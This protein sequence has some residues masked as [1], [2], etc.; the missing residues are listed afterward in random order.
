VGQGHRDPIQKIEVRQEFAA[1]RKLIRHSGHPA[2]RSGKLVGTPL[3]VEG[4]RA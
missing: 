1:Q 4:A 2:A 3:V